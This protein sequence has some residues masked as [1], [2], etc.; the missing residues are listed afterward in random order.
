MGPL[1]F[2]LYTGS[3][4]ANVQNK[5]PEISCHCYADDTQIYMSFRPDVL[6]QEQCISTIQVC[7]DY[8]RR[9]MLENKLMLNDNK[10]ELLLIGTPKQVSKL[11]FSG[12]SV[13][14]AVIKPSASARNLG[15]HLDKHLNMEDHITNVCK[16]TYYMIYNLRHIRKYLDKDCMKAVVHACITSKLDYCNGLLYGVPDSQIGRL[17]RVQN[18]CAR[19]IVGGSKFSRITPILRDPL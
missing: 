6:A 1:L 17:Q 10:T 8:I 16:S 18:I 14:N 19:L 2:T 9:W 13:G 3:L 7:V 12:V 11:E 4:I 5:F 15:V